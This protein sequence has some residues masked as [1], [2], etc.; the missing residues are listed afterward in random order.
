MKKWKC[1]ERVGKLGITCV[2]VGSLCG[3]ENVAMDEN[4]IELK[5]LA[6]CE[7]IAKYEQ[8]TK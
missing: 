6:V 3:R 8:I 1:W 7:K 2:G 4:V 5:M